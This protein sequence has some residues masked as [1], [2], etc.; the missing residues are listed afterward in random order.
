MFSASR[1][2]CWAENSEYH[3]R[4]T[5][6]FIFRLSLS[7][8][9]ASRQSSSPR[10]TIFRLRRPWKPEVVLRVLLWIAINNSPFWQ[11]FPSPMSCMSA[12]HE[13]CTFQWRNDV[14]EW[15]QPPLL[16]V[17]ESGNNKENIKALA[18]MFSWKKSSIC[19]YK[20]K[21]ITFSNNQHNT[22]LPC[23]R[24]I[25]LALRKSAVM[26][27]VDCK[28]VALPRLSGG[29]IPRPPPATWQMHLGGCYCRVW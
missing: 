20:P 11:V 26:Y 6:R 17:Q 15:L 5:I 7:G 4:Q 2:K 1:K 29:P 25:Y 9:F 18:K 27:R 22:H 16:N 12:G 14:Q 13:H 24:H 28:G 21:N 3:S 23:S 10:I 19:P 8:P